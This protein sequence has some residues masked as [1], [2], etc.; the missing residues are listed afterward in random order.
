MARFHLTPKRATTSEGGVVHPRQVQVAQAKVTVHKVT[1]TQI[2]MR[3]H[4]EAHWGSE[5]DEAKATT[6]NGPLAMG[7][8]SPVHGILEYDRERK[9]VTRFDLVAV[10]KM[11][12]MSTTTEPALAP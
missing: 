9:A 8:R 7:F 12:L 3:S 5:F 2:R 11:V 1:P 4:G 10:G 6:P